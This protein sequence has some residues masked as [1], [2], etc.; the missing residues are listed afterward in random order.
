MTKDVSNESGLCSLRCKNNRAKLDS[1]SIKS[2]SQIVRSSG[3]KIMIKGP[4]SS[5]SALHSL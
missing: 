1:G 4:T 5:M 2:L 3:R